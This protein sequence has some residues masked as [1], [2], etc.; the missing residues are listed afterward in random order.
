MLHLLLAALALAE[1]P[2]APPEAP[3][4]AQTSPQVVPPTP[5]ALLEEAVALRQAGDAEAARALLLAMA[6]R[7]PEELRA[8]WLYQRGVTEEIAWRPAEAQALYDAVIATGDPLALD[9]RFRRALVRE[10]LGDDAGALADV[11]AVGKARGLDEDDAVT[12]ALQRGIA[13]VNTGRVRAGVRR[14]DR[15]LALVESGDTHRYMRA[16]SRC[17]LAKALLAEA[18]ALPLDGRERRATRNLSTRAAHIA[19]AERQITALVAL[20]EP[21]WILASLVALGDGYAA[22]GD[23]LAAAPP[24]RRLT[25][26]QAELYRA[27]IARYVKNARTKAHHWYDAGVTL[28]ARLQWESPRV[29]LLRERRA[30]SAPP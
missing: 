5:G 17:T 25:D 4:D 26:A 28:A 7:V 1:A 2:I 13:E 30:G 23:A 8:A 10:D 11:L 14:I 21:E 16:K 12:L 18:A 20:Q 9:A 3:T 24:P 6:P 27:E 19:A 22:L 29:A 15:A